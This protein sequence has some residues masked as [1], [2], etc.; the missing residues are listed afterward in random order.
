M[1]CHCLECQRR[2]GSVLSVQAWFPL[3]RVA[4]AGAERSWTRLT[5]A[6]RLIRYRFCPECGSTVLITHADLPDLVGIPVGAFAD[7][8][9]PAPATSIWEQRRHRWAVVDGDDIAHVD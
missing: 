3:A 7:P 2:T 8:N 5:G 4:A 9:F 6:G 1:A